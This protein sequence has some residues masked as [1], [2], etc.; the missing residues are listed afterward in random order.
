MIPPELAIKIIKMIP[1]HLNRGYLFSILNHKEKMDYLEGSSIE[2]TFPN[3]E[4]FQIYREIKNEIYTIDVSYIYSYKF[5]NIKLDAI[6]EEFLDACL[7]FPIT[8]LCIRTDV[9][10]WFIYKFREYI[11]FLLLLKYKE[12]S[13]KLIRSMLPIFDYYIY[14]NLQLS[15]SFIEYST[16]LV[17]WR[18]VSMYQ[19]LEMDFIARFKDLVYWKYISN[20][21]KLSVNFIERHSDWVDWKSISYCQRLTLKFILKHRNKLDFDGIVQSQKL[22]KMRKTREFF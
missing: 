6:T 11:N 18:Y 14:R 12:Y 8:A 19:K 5:R 16:D 10:E 15:E 3:S 17:D 1:I 7:D 9:P 4:M 13:G 2:D 21:Q 22:R 20:C